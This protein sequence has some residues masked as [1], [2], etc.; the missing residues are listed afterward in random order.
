[1]ADNLQKAFN[2]SGTDTA[3]LLESIFETAGKD[4]EKLSNVLS[5]IDWGDPNTIAKLNDLIID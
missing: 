3:N 5:T 2:M 1:M 4:A